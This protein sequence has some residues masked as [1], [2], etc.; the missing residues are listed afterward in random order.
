MTTNPRL[1]VLLAPQ[2]TPQ[3]VGSLS[4]VW[5][6]SRFRGERKLATIAAFL[7]GRVDFANLSRKIEA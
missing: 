5:S 3:T 6:T 7:Q 4:D 2:D 1:T